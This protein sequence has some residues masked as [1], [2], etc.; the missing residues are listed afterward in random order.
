MH[1]AYLLYLATRT[2]TP[3]RRVRCCSDEPPSVPSRRGSSRSARWAKKTPRA[4]FASLHV[5]RR[6][7]ELPVD[8]RAPVGAA[9]V[10]KEGKHVGHITDQVVVL[11]TG[12]A[13]LVIERVQERQP[14][15][16]VLLVPP[17]A[18]SA[19]KDD[20][21]AVLGRAWEELPVA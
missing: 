13:A 5:F 3:E 20:G 2:P 4:I 14:N 6:S 21:V 8:T 18:I 11:K 10:T 9:V 16:I 19:T 1:N 12:R 17:E 7:F 15:V